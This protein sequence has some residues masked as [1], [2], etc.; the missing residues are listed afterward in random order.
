MTLDE[1]VHR[2]KRKGLFHRRDRGKIL[3]TRNNN[4]SN[5]NDYINVSM[6]DKPYP[7]KNTIPLRSDG[8][9]SATRT[10]SYIDN[11]YGLRFIPSKERYK[12]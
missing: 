9:Y 8:R 5:V 6:P 4:W 10:G 1:K 12:D 2:V 7:I 3:S 11:L